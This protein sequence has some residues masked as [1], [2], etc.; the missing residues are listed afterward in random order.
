MALFDGLVEDAA[1]RFGLGAQA[2]PLLRELLQVITGQPGGI[3]GFLNKLKAS[4][5]G[6][7]VGSWLGRSDGAALSAP[8][9]ETALGSNAVSG[10]VG[11]LGLGSSVVTA[12]LGYVVP[13]V[14]GLLTPGG[15]VPAGI[16]A[17]VSSFLGTTAQPA[18]RRVEQVM[19][20]SLQVIK[21][22]PGFARWAIP[23]AVVLGVLALL[24]YLFSGTPT[25]Q[26]ATPPAPA[27]Q[28]SATVAPPPVPALPPRLALSNDNGVVTYSGAVGDTTTRTT[29]IDAL[30][31]AFG[32]N[33]TKG[34]L[35]VNPNAG[36]AP[37]L[38][39]LRTVLETFK[40]PGV[41]AVFD[42]QSLDVGGAISDTVRDRILDSLKSAVGSGVVLGT[43]AGNASNGLTSNGLP[44][45]QPGRQP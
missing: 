17:A 4:D 44:Q 25:E 36:P 21:D 2:A 16:P 18:P 27:V 20:R 24:W 28:Q 9:V 8:Q 43:L 40:V 37:W 34:D 3:G 45:H 7:T 26:A 35:G 23:L 41:Q 32:A 39:N 30:K 5:L 14:I 12:A 13:K 19:P 38:V 6:P 11:R 42:G 1:S 29:I 22:T 15:V 33:A 10:I 31:A